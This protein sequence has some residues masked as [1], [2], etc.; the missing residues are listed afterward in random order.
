MH[1]VGQPPFEG[2]D[3]SMVQYLADAGMP[4]ARLHDVGGAYGRNVFVDI[5]NLFR[6]FSADETDPASYDFAFTDCL[7][8]ALADNG[9]EP[10]FRLY[11]NLSFNLIYLYHQ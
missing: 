9:V 7:M 3:F 5:P 6:D 4:Y 11:L 10:F 2:M 1:G 8:K